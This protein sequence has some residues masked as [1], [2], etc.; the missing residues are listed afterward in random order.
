M[1]DFRLR[2]TLRPVAASLLSERAIEQARK[3][4]RGFMDDGRLSLDVITTTIPPYRLDWNIPA[5]RAGVADGVYQVPYAADGVRVAAAAASN[6]TALF[7]AE[8]R[9]NGSTRTTV[10][11]QAGTNISQ[12]ATSVAIP[13]GSVVS[14]FV[15]R[16]PSV[17]ATVSLFLQATPGE[18]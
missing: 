11:I 2:E 14:V 13:A 7:S 6:T 18:E 15:T 9:V 4:E 1:D 17:A 16:S 3:V 5:G 12:G 8:I 10:A